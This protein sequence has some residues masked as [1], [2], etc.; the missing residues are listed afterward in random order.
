M[1][2]VIFLFTALLLLAGCEGMKTVLQSAARAS[3]PETAASF[4][5][6][7]RDRARED[8]RQRELERR[9][10]EF[11]L[12]RQMYAEA[13]SDTERNHVRRTYFDR[14]EHYE[15]MDRLDSLYDSSEQA[16][17][18]EQRRWFADRADSR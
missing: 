13:D 5:Q 10:K 2:K 11:E 4:D 15:H 7:R 6:A 1:K 17:F 14:M 12:V 16:R 18:D 3:D 8:G 9:D